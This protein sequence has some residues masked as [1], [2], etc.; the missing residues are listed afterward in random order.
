MKG[1][2]TRVRLI[3]A[4]GVAC[5]AV[6]DSSF[7]QSTPPTAGRASVPDYTLYFF[8]F[9]HITKQDSLA[10]QQTAVGK[11][12]NAIKTYYA[13]AVGLTPSDFQILHDTSLTCRASVALQDD[14][15]AQVIQNFRAAA[16]ATLRAN[17]PLPS[18][19]DQLA[20]MWGQ[21]NNIVLGCV[22]QLQKAMTPAGFQ[23]LDQYV[24]QELARN[25]LVKSPAALARKGAR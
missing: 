15:A 3:I 7:A 18:V 2:R 13:T 20:S 23:K 24:H 6:F 14:A 22:S 21:R 11:N 9:D 1:I 19:P 16:A 17:A 25:V 5:S 8:L 4:L 10:A 12:G